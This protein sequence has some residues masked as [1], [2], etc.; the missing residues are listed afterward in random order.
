M[1]YFFAKVKLFFINAFL[2][3]LLTSV[4]LF[5]AFF[6]ATI[7]L[8]KHIKKIFTKQTLTGLSLRR[9][10][11]T[12]TVTKSIEEDLWDIYSIASLTRNVIETYLSLHFFGLENISDEEAELRFFLLQ[13]HKN[14]EW[15]NIRKLTTLN[16][17]ELKEFE[18]GISEQKF[19]IKNHSYLP[20]LS[21]IHLR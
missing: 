20:K 5:V 13:L 18:E 16:K 21:Q 6:S 15:F 7:L 3:L 10:L 8:K 1:S 2:K 11:P 4:E 17:S 19:L 14:I 9:L 12:P